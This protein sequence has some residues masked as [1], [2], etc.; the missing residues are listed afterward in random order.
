MDDTSSMDGSARRHIQ[1]TKKAWLFTG[2]S[3]AAVLVLS[4]ALLSYFAY[5]LARE[6]EVKTF[7]AKVSQ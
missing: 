4:A 6:Q 2:V 1:A 3:A 5:Q 7:E